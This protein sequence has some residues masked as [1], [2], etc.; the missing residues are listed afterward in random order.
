MKRFVLLLLT[1]VSLASFAQKL[2]TTYTSK[3]P[4]FKLIEKDIE[5]KKSGFY[6]SDLK[7]R[8]LAADTTLTMEEMRHFYYGT[9]TRKGYDPY[10]NDLLQEL[11]AILRKDALT[12]ADWKK[13]VAIID[14]QLKSDPTNLTFYQYK[15][16]AC[17][18]LYGKDAKETYNA[19]FQ[20]VLL[21][22]AILSSGDGKTKES[23]IY[24][25]NVSDEYAIMSFYGLSLSKQM[26]VKDG[27]QEYDVMELGKNELGLENLYFNITVCSEALAKK[28]KYP[29]R[30]SF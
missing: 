7:K 19:Y 28:L 29:F 26:L 18:H 30:F 10:K 2:D 1:F 3:P 4:D 13:A 20:T 23:A 14:K 8:F 22:G 16:I 21:T 27:D 17:A 12:P 11:N 15:Q 5:S 9:S 6:Y 25:I 24:V